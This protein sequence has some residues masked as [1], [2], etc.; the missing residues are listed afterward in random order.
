MSRVNRKLQLVI[1]LVLVCLVGTMSIAYAVLS[2]TLNINGTAQVQDASWNVHFSNIQVNPYSVEINPVITDNNK[3]NFSADLTTPGEFYKFTVDIVNEGSI[4][5]MIES[6]AKTPELSVEQKKYLRYEVEYVDGTSINDAQLLK[7]GETKT[8][9]VL[10][11]YRNDIPVSDL[12]ST[13]TDFDLEIVLVYVQSNNTGVE[14]SGNEKIVK[15]V[16]GDLNTVGSEICIGEECFYLMKNDGYTVTMLAKYNLYAGNIVPDSSFSI[17]PINNEIIKQD[18]IA[19]GAFFD[20]EHNAVNFPWHGTLP[21]ASTDYWWNYDNNSYISETMLD[22]V[23][24][25][26]TFTYVYNFSSKLYTYVE[27]YKTYL[28]SHNI[29]VKNARLI[30]MKD[31]NELGCVHNFF[32]CLEAPKWVYSTSYWTGTVDSSHIVWRVRSDSI[33][34]DYSYTS[35]SFGIRPVIEIALTEF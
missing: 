15:V 19:L 1:L 5:A 2:T 33:I 22:C 31:L 20:D 14:I 18:P 4:D 3:V 32:S 24:N 8:I 28:E 29:I 21:F 30:K 34:D 10:F 16:S 17:I 11:S 9:S 25:G 27:K 26:E 7:S 6:V 12:P 35:L 23:I 13:E